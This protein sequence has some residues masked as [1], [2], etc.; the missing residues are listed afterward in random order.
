MHTNICYLSK[1]RYIANV[2]DAPKKIS[3]DVDKFFQNLEA[4]NKGDI[5][6]EEACYRCIY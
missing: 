1:Y 6:L 3:A 5:S 4:V 2:L